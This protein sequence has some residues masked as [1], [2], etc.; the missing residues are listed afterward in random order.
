MSE[1]F[2]EDEHDHA[3][4]AKHLCAHNENFGIDEVFIDHVKNGKFICK[5][6]GRV[7][8][9]KDYLCYPQEL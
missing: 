6:C 5:R 8:T 2:K 9:S 4:H 7:A 3:N 1:E